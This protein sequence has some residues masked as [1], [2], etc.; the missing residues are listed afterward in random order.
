MA[1]DAGLSPFGQIRV[2]A[3][4][5]FNSITSVREIL[6]MK[7]MVEAVAGQ[8][9]LCWKPPFVASNSCTSVVTA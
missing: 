8:A 1:T 5:V 2:S 3:E 7:L 9:N 6:K 4:R